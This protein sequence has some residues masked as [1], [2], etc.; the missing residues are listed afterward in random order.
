[1][2]S[3]TTSCE[4]RSFTT[5]R[6]TGRCRFVKFLDSQLSAVEYETRCPAIT[7][8]CDNAAQVALAD[9]FR[10]DEQKAGERPIFYRRLGWPPKGSVLEDTAEN[11]I[12]HVV[13]PPDELLRLCQNLLKVSGLLYLDTLFRIAWGG[14]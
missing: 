9:T 10:S 1:M 11:D 8:L 2:F 14:L 6:E 3:N 12:H 13:M 5:F 7:K 4:A